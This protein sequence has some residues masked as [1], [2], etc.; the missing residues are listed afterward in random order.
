MPVPTSEETKS[1]GSAQPR[2]EFG[3]SGRKIIYDKDGKPY[4]CDTL[5]DHLSL[6]TN[7]Q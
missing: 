3:L 6:I 2:P 7:Q 1:D 4:V 5:Y